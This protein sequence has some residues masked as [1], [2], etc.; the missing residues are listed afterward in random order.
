MRLSIIRTGVLRRPLIVDEKT[1][2]IIDGTHR[3]EALKSMGI[4]RIPVIGVDYLSE[5]EV[6]IS[7]WIRIYVLKSS[8]SEGT[9]DIED[10]VAS[11]QEVDVKRIGRSFVVMV[12][13]REPQEIYRE[14]ASLEKS[15]R[16]AHIVDRIIF[17][18]KIS[19]QMLRKTRSIAIA[20]PPLT[21]EEVIKAGVNGEPFPPKSTR[22]ITI[23]KKLE[24]RIGVKDLTI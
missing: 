16:L 17:R 1:G 12:K 4:R 3:Y 23:L 10:L 7:S 6:R 15:P 2:V 14:I 9:V 5:N 24:L 13:K 11:L 8:S 21:K 20:P 22:H 18:P 19:Y